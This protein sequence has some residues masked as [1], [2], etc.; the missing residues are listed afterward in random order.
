LTIARA[1]LADPAILILDEATS[2]VDTRTEIAIQK[3]MAELMKGRTSFVIAHRLSTIRDADLILV[4]NHGSIIEQELFDEARELGVGFCLG[5]ALLELDSD[6]STRR[7]NVQTLVERGV[8]FQDTPDA[9]FDG[10]EARLPGHG[11]PLQALRYRH[12]ESTVDKVE[13]QLKKAVA[14][15]KPKMHQVAGS[16][17]RMEALALRLHRSGQ[18]WTIAQYAYASVGVGVGFTVLIYLKTGAALLSLVVGVLAGAGLPHMVVGRNIKKRTNKFNARFPEA[19]E[20]LV[21]GQL[22]V[23][24]ADLRQLCLDSIDSVRI[25]LR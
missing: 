15:R 25:R 6:G 9:Y 21:R 19:I 20:L 4:M 2:S 3:A 16:G 7:W 11:E 22:A 8:Q 13:A 14:A 23:T 24:V 18:T 5:Y 10:I 17:S 1:F 12:S